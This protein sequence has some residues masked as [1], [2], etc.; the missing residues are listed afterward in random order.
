MEEKRDRT[1][2][3]SKFRWNTLLSVFV[4]IALFFFM[5]PLITS[6]STAAAEQEY[7]E[8]ISELNQDLVAA[9]TGLEENQKFKDELFF[10]NQ[11][12]NKDLLACREELITANNDINNLNEDLSSLKKDLANV[13][14]EEIQKIEEEKT[15]LQDKIDELGTEKDD[16][17][18]DY[19]S[20]AQ[21]L[22]NSI[23][24]KQKVDKWEINY[25]SIVNH[26]IVCLEDGDQ[27]IS[28]PFG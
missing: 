26:N 10:Q 6:Y 1:S 14:T 12:L 23:C 27:E 7:S 19:D 8:K 15:A 16:L 9:Q 5:K 20:L 22:A 21:N 4:I 24:C 25:Y 11:G 3:F 17:Q 2:I 28:C 18:A 13:E